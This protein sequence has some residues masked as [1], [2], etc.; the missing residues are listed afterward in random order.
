[1]TWSPAAVLTPDVGD[2]SEDVH[3]LFLDIERTTGRRGAAGQCTPPLDVLETDE[4]VEVIVDLPGVTR[5]S[6]RVLLKGNVIVVAGEKETDAREAQDV[7][8]F[9]LVERVYGRFARAI[10]VLAAF[11]G[12][13]GRAILANGELRISLPKIHDRRGQPR[14][15]PIG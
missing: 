9:H 5:D 14:I 7:R 15:V 1:M 13:R 10:R 3:R 11:D 2:L 6:V 12:A 8:A 4:V